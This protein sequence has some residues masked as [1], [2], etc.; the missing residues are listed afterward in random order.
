[1]ASVIWLYYFGTSLLRKDFSRVVIYLKEH[2]KWVY[3]F[4]SFLVS[5]S[6]VYFTFWCSFYSKWL[7]APKCLSYNDSVTVLRLRLVH[8]KYNTAQK[9][10]EKTSRGIR[11]YCFFSD[12]SLHLKQIGFSFWHVLQRNF[13]KS[14]FSLPQTLVVYV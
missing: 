11:I 13:L 6:M 1:M 7:S 4:S 12:C 8:Q 2:F 10:N 3:L 5:Y 14:P 9:T